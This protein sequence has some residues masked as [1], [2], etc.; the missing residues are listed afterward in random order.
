MCCSL[1]IAKVNSAILPSHFAPRLR[2]RSVSIV[3]IRSTEDETFARIS[4]KGDV[5]CRVTFLARRKARD[6][7]GFPASWRRFPRRFLAEQSR[8]ESN[9]GSL[10]FFLS[11]FSS[12]GSLPGV[13]GRGAN[14]DSRFTYGD[15]IAA[16]GASCSSF[17]GRKF[18]VLTVSGGLQ[19]T[20]GV[21]RA[22]MVRDKNAR[23]V[24]CTREK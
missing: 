13:V 15:A 18:D 11:P 9:T 17:S 2:E 12:G 19:R 24:A 8:A 22:H 4:A 3:L 16:H 7:H 6:V 23:G 20:Y 21:T 14:F 10:I 5:H 1:S